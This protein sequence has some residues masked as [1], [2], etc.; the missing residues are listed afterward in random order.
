MMM[1]HAALAFV[2]GFICLPISHADVYK[3]TDN[4]GRVHFGDKPFENASLETIDI[5]INSYQAVTIEPLTETQANNEDR[6]IDKKVVMYST[7]WCGYCKKARRYF[8]ANNIPYREFDI[9]D[10][11]K[12]KK[13][14]KSLGGNGVPLILVGKNKI[15]GFN[16]KSF[17]QVYDKK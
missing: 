17:Q 15:S 12:A 8:K 11:P 3:W 7:S 10:S 16:E 4:H 1:R 6:T 14:F 2:I 9:E 13:R 5:K